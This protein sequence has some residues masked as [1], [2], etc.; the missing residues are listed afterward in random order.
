M[1]G[2]KLTALPANFN[3]LTGLREL[4]IKRNPFKTSPW[5]VL[6]KMTNLRDIECDVKK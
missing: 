4:D 6:N 5:P 1:S 2:N 3:N